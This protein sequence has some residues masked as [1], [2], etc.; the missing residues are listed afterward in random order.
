MAGSEEYEGKW[1]D[2]TNILDREWK[3]REKVQIRG[4]DRRKE[5]RARR[6][7]NKGG[8]DHGY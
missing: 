6:S 3:A 5:E 2:G 7:G 1:R 4:G 8:N